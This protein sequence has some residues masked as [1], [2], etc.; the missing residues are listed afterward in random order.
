MSNQG[1]PKVPEEIYTDFDL[2][3]DFTP[4]TFS[5]SSTRRT[6]SIRS[7]ANS[8]PSSSMRN[9]ATERS[10][11]DVASFS[12]SYKTSTMS[13][14]HIYARLVPVF[15]TFTT[16]LLFFGF[17]CFFAFHAIFTSIAPVSER[18][19]S[20]ANKPYGNLGNTHLH[21]PIPQ[22]DSIR[23]PEAYNSFQDENLFRLQKLLQ[24][25]ELE[26]IIHDQE[27]SENNE[28]IIPPTNDHLAEDPASADAYLDL[29]QN[30][31]FI[32]DYD[33]AIKKENLLSESKCHIPI[34][35][36]ESLLKNRTKIQPCESGDTNYGI[37]DTKECCYQ[38]IQSNF[39]ADLQNE[40]WKTLVCTPFDPDDK[41]SEVVLSNFE[42]TRIKCRKSPLHQN[43]DVV[44]TELWARISLKSPIV[45]T[46]IQH[47]VDQPTSIR[48]PMN[49][50]I[51]GLDGISRQLF[52]DSFIKTRKMLKKLNFFN[53]KGYHIVGQKTLDNLVP[54]L[55]DFSEKNY[56]T[57]YSEDIP[58]TFNFGNQK[59]FK[60]SPTDYYLRPILLE[61]L[62]YDGNSHCFGN[63]TT[64]EFI[65]NY[66][67]P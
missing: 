57:M 23:E 26:D 59:G 47:W 53:L 44:K 43:K 48:K 66:G 10:D 4:R 29:V 21:K 58:D 16:V 37:E 51:L 1:I 5:T 65:L 42:F 63:Q 56:V 18:A 2:E 54:L 46:K 25:P 13:P 27:I 33:E 24:E 22:Y 36:A 9:S 64:T 62:H 32:K 12:T 40:L 61:K 41:E 30:F 19:P 45:R 11:S 35:S 67:W 15:I 50:I 14:F 8:R 38:V 17:V 34:L 6:G 39:D 20:I 3:S 55:M 60:E 7:S 31:S 52:H 49:I 28:T